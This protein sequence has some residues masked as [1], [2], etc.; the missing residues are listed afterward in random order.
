M[1]ACTTLS[2]ILLALAGSSGNAWSQAAS[3][4]SAAPTAP[5]SAAPGSTVNT[6]SVALATVPAGPFA[7]TR[8]DGKGW[9]VRVPVVVVEGKAPATLT[10]VDA[11]FKEG[12]SIGLIESF[13]P[14]FVAAGNNRGPALELDTG[15]KDLMPGSYVLSLTLSESARKSAPQ[16]MT[17]TVTVGAPQI[18]AETTKV[19]VAQIRELFGGTT[20]GDGTLKVSWGNGPAPMSLTPV[21]VHDPPANGEA[22]TAGLKFTLLSAPAAISTAP[23]LA[24]Q[25]AAFN[26]FPLGTTIGRIDLH[27]PSLAT[28]VSVPFVAYVRRSYWWI[29]VIAALGAFAG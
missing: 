8:K 1:R 13:Q 22:D 27:S 10:L 11:L 15:D 24:Y 14:R 3:A 4:A 28:P 16:A 18:K 9:A 20:N 12:R 6:T 7:L 5:G 21:D 2:A 19:V 26:R 23:I 29:S 17:L 25:V